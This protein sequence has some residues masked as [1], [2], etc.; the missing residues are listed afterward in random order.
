MCHEGSVFHAAAV[1]FSTKAPWLIGLCSAA[2]AWKTLPSWHIYGSMDM[3][4]P[5]AAMAFMAERAHARKTVV[6]TGGSHVTLISHP[7]EV[8]ALIEAAATSS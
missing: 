8:A 1:T 2:A 4:I 6:V 7:H 3:A 5:P